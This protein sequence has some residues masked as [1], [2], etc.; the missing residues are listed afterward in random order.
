[1]ATISGKYAQLWVNSREYEFV[2][3]E[4]S[5]KYDKI[6]TTDSSTPDQGMDSIVGWSESTMKIEALVASALGEEVATGTCV[7]GTR[8]L[9]TGGSIVETQGTF[10][11]GRLFESDG[12]GALSGTNKVKALGTKLKGKDVVCTIGGSEVGV[13][14]MSYSEKYGEYDKTNSMT[15]GDVKEYEA[16]RAE[17]T[18]KIEVIADSATAD[19]LTSSPSSQAVVLTWGSGDAI[20]GNARIMSKTVPVVVEG[21]FVKVTY[22]LD[23]QGVPANTMENLLPRATSAATKLILYPGA[24]TNKEYTGNTIVMGMEISTDMN[25]TVKVSYDVKWTGAVTEAVAN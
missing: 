4:H 13:I 3:A 5:S 12:T 22:E 9:V 24:T 18:S 20:T 25:S 6:P 17:R 10:A 14:S 23:W 15:S 2:S 1:M 16:G 19:K 21:D 8:Y 11:L 7:A